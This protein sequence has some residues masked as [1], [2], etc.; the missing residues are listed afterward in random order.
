MPVHRVNTSRSYLLDFVKEAASSIPQGAT[1]LDAGAGR[2]P[3]KS[4]FA[5]T[6]Y[7]STDFCQIDDYH[8]KDITYVCDLTDIP[9]PDNRYDLV[10]LTQVL[11]HLP[12]PKLVL[13]ELHR[14][15]KPGGSLW[16]TTPLFYEEHDIPYDYYRY[17]QYGLRHLLST[18]GFDVQSLTWL[19]GY[20]GTLSQQLANAYRSLPLNPREYATGVWRF[21]G[22]LAAVVLKPAFAGLSL[23]Y[24]KL[25]LHNKFTSKGL[26]KNY[27]V[28]A[29]KHHES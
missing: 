19:E 24:A 18:T 26:C 7:E 21:I 25:D 8:Y 20:Y 27:A 28:V 16:L 10:L 23:L 4:L 2:M 13:T 12:E 9:V 3:Y 6:R 29:I 17:T 5:H 11:E 15:L 1:V 22:P 14:I